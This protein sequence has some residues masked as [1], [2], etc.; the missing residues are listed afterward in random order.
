MISVKKYI[1]HET[2]KLKKLVNVRFRIYDKGTHLSYTSNIKIIPTLWDL[3]SQLYGFSNQYIDPQYKMV[4]EQLNL[5]HTIILQV[6]KQYDK[7]ELSSKLLTDEVNRE[8]HKLETE[9]DL[10]NKPF[11]D[12]FLDYVLN[13]KMDKI[14]R[15]YFK[16]V[17]KSFLAFERYLMIVDKRT[18]MITYNSI[19]HKLLNKFADFIVN[20]K[21]IANQYP[22]IHADEKRKLQERCSET[23][24]N[25]LRY[26]R[27][28]INKVR[29]DAQTDFYPMKNYR[30][31]SAKMNKPVALTQ[32]E[33]KQLYDFTSDNEMLNLIRDNFLLQLCT[34]ARVDDFYHIQYNSI[35]YNKSEGI[36]YLCFT[37]QKTAK[38]SG[39]QVEIPF[40]NLA[41]ELTVKYKNKSDCLIP[42][43]SEQY[44][45][46]KLKVLF[47]AAGLDRII[48][49]YDKVRKTDVQKPLYSLATSHTARKTAISRLYN[50]GCPLDM[51]N[52]ICGHVG[53]DIKS[54]YAEFDL[55]AKLEYMNQICPWYIVEQPLIDVKNNAI[56]E[57]MKIENKKFIPFVANRMVI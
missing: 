52:D 40:N 25:Y 47:E 43:Y 35:L 9:N 17:L 36:N 48:V 12:C 5:I 53:D 14:R 42:H 44:Y 31:K 49:K 34:V 30:I 26:L 11:A 51:I 56:V 20:E 1:R 3:N 10:L 46:R 6:C 39:K 41:R 7:T 33:I 21:E 2:I 37:P 16:V 29:E 27:C 24:D 55:S 28:V 13:H 8:L 54:R 23:G 22:E 45:N 15:N 19:T 32:Y 4:N 50:A 18:K 38:S 57:N